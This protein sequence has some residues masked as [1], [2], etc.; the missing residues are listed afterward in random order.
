MNLPTLAVLL[1]VAGASP[2]AR[3]SVQ[4]LPARLVEGTFFARPVTRSGRTLNLYTDTGGGLWLTQAVAQELKLPTRTEAQGEEKRE[5]LTALPE[6]RPG[7]GIP[8]PLEGTFG[9]MPKQEGSPVP[10]GWDGML[11]QEWFAGRVWT[12]D[13]PRGQLLLHAKAPPMEGTHVV[14][15]G[16]RVGKDGK[17]ET[18]FARIQ[19]QVDGEPLDLLFDTGA[20]TRLT[21]DAAKALKVAAGERATSFIT[22]SVAE[23]WRSRH[24]DWRYVE[25]AE[26]GTGAPMIQVPHLSVA[27]HEVGPVWFT[28][29]PDRAFHEY[30]A[31]WM[32]KPTEGALGGS[33]LHYFR[34]TVD[35]PGARALFER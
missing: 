32:D 18:A 29:R 9:V 15:L 1:S 27:G 12:F 10:A 7:Q 6:F 26:A 4:R 24:P 16:F 23:R 2:E 11:G 34:I 17:R 5:V 31:Q 20:Q 19:V 13:Y 8:A 28:L 3:P 33:A 21:A 22:K 25:A 30:M 35:Y 14:P